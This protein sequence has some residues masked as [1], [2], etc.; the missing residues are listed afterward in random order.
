[1]GGGFTAR[2]STI[3]DFTNCEIMKDTREHGEYI[4]GLADLAN[5][6]WRLRLSHNYAHFLFPSATSV[7]PPILCG[8]VIAYPAHQAPTHCGKKASSVIL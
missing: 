8:E 6:V 7:L 5:C 3:V 1:M 2:M 4:G